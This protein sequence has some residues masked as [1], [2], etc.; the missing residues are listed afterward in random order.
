M[1]N[2]ERAMLPVMLNDWPTVLRYGSDII[3]KKLLE[4]IPSD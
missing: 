1:D 3:V 4:L 2:D